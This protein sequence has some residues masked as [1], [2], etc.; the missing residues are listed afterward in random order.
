[1]YEKYITYDYLIS[2][3]NGKK[4][5]NLKNSKKTILN[6][7]F[8]SIEE[9]LEKYPN[10]P[11]RCQSSI[12]K[13]LASAKLKAEKRIDFCKQNYY[14]NP[15]KC[16]YCNNIIPYEC[17]NTNTFCNSSCSCFFNNKKR[18]EN[19]YM[20]SSETK[21]KISKKL[22]GRTSKIK[23]QKLGHWNGTEFVL[24]SHVGFN[25]CKNCGKLFCVKKKHPNS[26][27]NKCC[28][29]ICK[30]MLLTSRPYLNGSRKTIKYFN[31]F[32]NK[33]II[34]ESSWEYNIAQF[35]DE[36]NIK[37]IRPEPII[38]LDSY[39]KS[40]L[41]YPDFYIEEKKLYIDPKNPYCMKLDN[42]KMNIVSKKINI[43]Y[44][45]VNEIK[46]KLKNI[47]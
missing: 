11:L 13:E 9:L 35:L 47:F 39:K 38:W 19:G 45:D 41:Y 24:I 3:I 32:I 8:Y 36:N 34:L 6:F 20:V 22:K 16:L 43:I 17:K 44:G 42:E 1:M 27:T 12:D 46:N 10:F 25:N 4:Y 40:H 31:K 23:G 18:E 26:E 28:S 7:G 30:T 29:D 21:N 15:K 14:N 2:P 33:E 37:W 5:K